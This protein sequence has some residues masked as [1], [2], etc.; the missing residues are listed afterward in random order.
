MQD[1][2]FTAFV[3]E[4]CTN[5]KGRPVADLKILDRYVDMSCLRPAHRVSK[6]HEGSP[7]GFGQNQAWEVGTALW[8]LAGCRTAR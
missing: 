2:L 4:M 5:M 3:E 1:P 7:G 8:A 6:R